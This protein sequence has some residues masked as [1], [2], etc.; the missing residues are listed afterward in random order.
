M[1]E[2]LERKV[3][4][5]MVALWL[6][7]RL[8]A[9]IH[10]R[11]NISKA[12]GLDAMKA[13]SAALSLLAESS[14]A[15]RSPNAKRELQNVYAMAMVGFWIEGE[16]SNF[17][18]CIGRISK[19]MG[20]RGWQVSNFIFSILREVS[21]ALLATYELSMRSS[22]AASTWK[23]GLNL[24]VVEQNLES[25]VLRIM[26]G[27]WLEQRVKSLIHDKDRMSKILSVDRPSYARILSS[28]REAS[29]ALIV[30][31]IKQSPDVDVKPRIVLWLEKE[32]EDLNSNMGRVSKRMGI[33]A[34]EASGLVL[35][36]LPEVSEALRVAYSF[37]QRR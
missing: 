33:S 15:L 31:D 9:L 10:D 24:K 20:L 27:W 18:R 25:K 17:R 2:S 21:E 32:L 30:E 36:L 35:S 5:V 1:E 11:D 22:F 28:I 26:V 34:H 3:L 23:E 4:I 14:L 8:N 12:L 16:L 37:E 6:E 7:Q 13:R 19:V 29:E